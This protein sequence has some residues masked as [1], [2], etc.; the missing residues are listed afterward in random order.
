MRL[1]PGGVRKPHWQK[2]GEW[3]FMLAGNARS[4]YP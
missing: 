1:T 3:S 4:N 2:E